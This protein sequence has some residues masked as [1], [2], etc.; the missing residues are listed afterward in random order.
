MENLLK[1]AVGA[2]GGYR[3]P[4]VS[5]RTSHP[6]GRGRVSAAAIG[7]TTTLEAYMRKM[8]QK[9]IQVRRRQRTAAARTAPPVAAGCSSGCG[10]A[11]TAAAAVADAAADAAAA[12]AADGTV[13]T[14]WRLCCRDA[15][16]AWDAAPGATSNRVNNM[17]AR[18]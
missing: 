2:G 9:A 12:A 11:E 3:L 6:G 15:G 5:V 4:E 14:A 16:T 8:L 18:T 10:A 1:G 13:D 7:W 17:N